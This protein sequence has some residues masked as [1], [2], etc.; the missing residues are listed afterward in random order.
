M[1]PETVGLGRM[2]GNMVR[3]L[4]KGEHQCVVFDMSSRAVD[5]L[6]QEKADGSSS[7]QELIRSLAKPRAIW[8]MVPAAAVDK[9]IAE[10]SP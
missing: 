5:G 1:Q 4:L 3:C 8:L 2:G 7:M 6:V 9:T 10:L